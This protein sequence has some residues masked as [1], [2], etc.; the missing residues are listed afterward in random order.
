MKVVSQFHPRIKYDEAASLARRGNLISIGQTA[1]EDAQ[2][3]K[4]LE[5]NQ[6]G[7]GVQTESLDLMQAQF[8][9]MLAHRQK[10]DE[11]TR[12]SALNKVSLRDVRDRTSGMGED[13][14]AQDPGLFTQFYEGVS[15]TITSLN[16]LPGH[17]GLFGF[18]AGDVQPL[19]AE[20]REASRLLAEEDARARIRQFE[21]RAA[22]KAEVSG[23][24][25]TD[26][27]EEIIDLDDVPLTSTTTKRGAVHTVLEEW[28]SNPSIQTTKNLI[29]GREDDPGFVQGAIQAAAAMGALGGVGANLR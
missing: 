14:R 10:Q 17:M 26:E 7:L 23:R 27:N 25:F 29:L 5:S 20:Q 13:P 22:R 19:N 6:R 21:E 9:A 28:A 12:L 8:L 15:D 3:R 11:L 2:I 18:N 24:L 4:L 16:N 1:R